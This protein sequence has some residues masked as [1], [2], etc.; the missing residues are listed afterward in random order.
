MLTVS[1]KSTRR[2]THN[3]E[4]SRKNAMNDLKKEGSFRVCICYHPVHISPYLPTLVRITS[5]HLRQHSNIRQHVTKSRQ[6]RC[7][8]ER[9]IGNQ[10]VNIFLSPTDTRAVGTSSVA[11]WPMG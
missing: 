3:T 8:R 11:A 6:Q 4:V 10:S 9:G 2:R 1:Q 5:V 7:Q